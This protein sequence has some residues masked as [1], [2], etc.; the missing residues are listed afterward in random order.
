LLNCVETGTQ[1]SNFILLNRSRIV[2]N[3]NDICVEEVELLK[4]AGF[5]GEIAEEALRGLRVNTAF[6]SCVGFSMQTGLMEADTRE[7]N[8]KQQMIRSAS[9]VVA[10]VDFSKFG[11]MGLKTFA[12]IDQ[13][14][15]LVTDDGIDP[16]MV[17]QLRS[18]DVSLI[19]CGEAS[20]QSLTPKQLSQ[21]H[22]RIGFANLSEQLPFSI[23]VRRSLER[24]ARERHNVDIVYVDNNLDGET[25]IQLADELI[26]RQVDLVIE[27][28]I[29]EHAGNILMNQFK[30]HNIPVIA[31]D[32]PMVGAT[33]FGV[34]N[35]HAG[36]LAGSALGTWI[37]H[38]WQGQLDY[39]LVLEEKRA[40]T[41]PAARIQG[42]LSGLETSLGQPL[43]DKLI[44]LDSG[45]N[46]RRSYENV[47]PILK[48]L[49]ESARIACICF[50]DDAAMGALQAAH[51]L[52]LA[53]RV[54]IVG[55]GSDRQIRAEL[56]REGSP[57]I[58]STAFMPEQ[59]GDRLIEIAL[60]ILRGDVVPPAVYM[61]HRFI[62]HFNVDSYYPEQSG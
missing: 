29:D 38:Y 35:F 14:S 47:Q 13:L 56:R 25:A 7:A 46:T 3:K 17:Q 28:Q 10:L 36:M 42:Q 21:S 33:Y 30:Q 55:Q 40:G 59:Y 9:R 52:A 54:T 27:Y 62:D 15:Y 11:K 49:P 22:Y 5:D 4:T 34:D 57:V 19:V 23:D 48:K 41:L 45:N 43:Q 37:H 16:Q 18:A 32:I 61:E 2:K 39:V 1:G 31:V 8:L 26:A 24:A 44:F 58:G 53:D 50:N 60:K 51:E 6:L 20:V 12:T